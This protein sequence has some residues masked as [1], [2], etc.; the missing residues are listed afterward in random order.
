PN[1]ITKSA[2]ITDRVNKSWGYNVGNGPLWQL[3]EDRGWYKEANTD[4]GI[5]GDDATEREESEAQ[6]RPRVY[7]DVVVKDG[8][9]VLS[10]EEAALYLPT[11]DITT[12]EGN[13]RPPPPVQCYLGPYKTQT[14]KELSMFDT[15][16]M[17]TFFP[18]SKAQVFNAGAPVWGLDW[19]PIHPSERKAWNHK[20]YLAVGVYPSKN[21]S[22]DVGV[23]AKRPSK[24]CIQLWSYGPAIPPT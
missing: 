6:R 15:V 9:E 20:R 1:S 7:A 23:K 13:L 2:R 22:P 21:H 16:A 19:C 4:N 18:E 8:W 5:G 11:D 12:E 14:K 3:V 24:A 10:M 17:S